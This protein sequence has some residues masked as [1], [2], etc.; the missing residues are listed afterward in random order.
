[1]S[2]GRAAQA[3][4]LPL[5]RGGAAPV[6]DDFGWE[7]LLTLAE[8]HGL[9]PLLHEQALQGLAPLLHEQA[10]RGLALPAA[11]MVHLKRARAAEVAQEA[12]REE[13]LQRTLDALAAAPALEVLLLKGAASART[14]Y[15]SPEL[16]PRGD[17]D[18]LVHP[19]QFDAAL[20]RLTARGFVHHPK[21]RG[22]R[23]ER[24][25][26]HERTLQDPEAPRLSLDLHRA[27]L[28]PER[29]R[30]SAEGLFA[31]SQP[32]PGLPGRARLACAE[33]ALLICALS[34]GAHELR[35]PLLL[36]CDLLLLLERCRIEESAAR[37]KETRVA[38]ALWLSLRWLGEITAG[39]SRFCGL[40]VPRAELAALLEALEV[41]LHARLALGSIARRYALSRRQPGRLEQL[42]RKG[43][44]LDSAR[45]AARFAAASLWS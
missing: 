43:W 13:L 9:A 20:E 19:A 44:I 45:D 10:L 34:I 21:T 30:L 38:R 28:Q 29:Q 16:R 39:A 18:L 41:P 3:A 8:A 6:A 35:V 11:A 24:P 1:V 22:T 37:A 32:A 12:R 15:T 26:W 5:L 36:A 14:L 17:L 31:R 27:L 2:P 4:L 40:P 7:A 23:E 25:D 33:D 42:W